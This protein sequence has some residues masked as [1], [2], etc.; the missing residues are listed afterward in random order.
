MERA[1]G[2]QPG[3]WAPRALDRGRA[4]RRGFR[5][6]VRDPVNHAE[7]R[8][9]SDRLLRHVAGCGSDRGVARARG[10]EP[11]AS[12]PSFRVRGRPG[13]ERAHERRG[14]SGRFDGLPRWPRHD[15]RRRDVR[16]RRRGP[17]RHRLARDPAGRAAA[18]QRSGAR[19]VR[20]GRLAERERGLEGDGARTRAERGAARRGRVGKV[21]ASNGG[22]RGRLRLL[23]ARERARRRGRGG[24]EGRW[25]AS[26][27]LGERAV[28]GVSKVLET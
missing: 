7:G 27:Q 17:L 13:R 2:R 6:R 21:R 26:R 16:C 12:M 23:L 22:D 14:A 15:R 8:I 24:R 9:A 5:R 11:A 28:E 3:I 10:R 19:R 1:G 18:S 25:K 20:E 4:A